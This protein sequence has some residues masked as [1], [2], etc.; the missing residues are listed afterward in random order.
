[1]C[2]VSIC[3]QV[4]DINKNVYGCHVE[5]FVV[6]VMDLGKNLL[7]CFSSMVARAF[8][9]SLLQEGSGFIFLIGVELTA[10]WCLVL[11]EIMIFFCICKAVTL[12]YLLFVSHPSGKTTD[13][14]QPCKSYKI[15]KVHIR[16]NNASVMHQPLFVCNI[17]QLLIRGQCRIG[18]S[19]MC[20][21]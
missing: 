18:H 1:M 10:S 9:L 14:S 20:E 5:C 3:K 15:A 8:M 16:Q 11:G 2:Y 21:I 12:I 6:R 7:V 4:C 17:C 13:S 19:C